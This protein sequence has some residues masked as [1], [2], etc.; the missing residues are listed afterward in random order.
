MSTVAGVSTPEVQLGK[1]RLLKLLATGGMG[2]V[3]LAR[4]EGPAGFAKTVVIKR[5]LPHLGRDPKFVEMFLNEARLAAELSHPNIVQIFELGEHGGTYFLAME[6]IHGVNL[7]T[8][9]RRMDERHLEVPAGFA[10]WICA[11]ALKGL[12]YAH[13]LTN[14]AGASM[15]VVHRDVSPDNVLVGFNGTVKMVDFGI[16]KASTSLSTTNAGTVKGKYAYMS[17]EQ[18]SG[19]KADPRTDVYAMGIVLYEF[20]TGGRP[21]QGPSEGALVRSILQD[22][23]KPPREIRPELAPELEEISLRAIARNPQERFPSAESMAVALEGYALG[24]GAMT[25]QKVKNLLRAL[26][27]EEADIISAV[28]TRPKSG[29]SLN[30][31]PGAAQVGSASVSTG[32][33]S[34]LKKTGDAPQQTSSQWVN[35]DLSTHFTVSIAEVPVPVSSAALSPAPAPAPPPPSQPT[36]RFAP[37]LVAGGGAVALLVGAGLTLPALRD[38]SGAAP[39]RVSLQTLPLAGPN[40]PPPVPVAVDVAPMPPEAP[41]EAVPAPAPPAPETQAAA[42]ADSD[43]QAPPSPEKRAARPAAKPSSGTVSL[44]VNP[45]AEVLYAGKSLGVTPMAPFELPSGTH[46]LT[47]VNQDLDVKRKVRVVVP[48]RREV[49]LRINLLDG[50]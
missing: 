24:A 45:W 14:E 6:F 18:L 1:Y 9:K 35:V 44:R 33:S 7:R 19:Q 29:G 46:T 16:A 30:A 10:A 48:A 39:A 38:S 13:T 47:L 4:Q 49:V 41:A 8:L 34:A 28:S 23:P 42:E 11:Q 15:N 27:G 2:E 12:H 50:M 40:S 31:S 26:F 5:M 20:I 32:T 25:Q 36:R 21:F 37:W 22:T 17:P 43:E 3:F